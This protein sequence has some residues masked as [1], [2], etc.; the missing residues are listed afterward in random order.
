MSAANANDAESPALGSLKIRLRHDIHWIAYPNTNR[1]VA[2]DPIA[3]AFY[4]FSQLEYQAAL[5]LDGSRS[6]G[7]VLETVRNRTLNSSPT[8]AWIESFI[9]KLHRSELIESPTGFKT[10]QLQTPRN[11]N[12]FFNSLLANPLSIRIPLLRPSIEYAWAQWLAKLL[13]SP[14]AITA[15]LIGLLIVSYSVAS[16]LLSRPNEIL[17]DVSKIQGDRWLVL[18]ALL[19]AIKSLHE[20][21]HYLAC[22]HLKVR[23]AEIGALFLCFTPCLYCDTTESWKLPSRAHRAG[24]A[25]A[26][27]YLE[28]W[29]ALAGGLVFLNTQSGLAHVLGGGL[30]I[31]C[32]LGTLLLNAN[33]FFRYDG[34][35]ILSDLIGAP[36]LGAQGSQ[37]LW[38]SFIALLGGP[39]ANP[40]DFDLPIGWLSVFAILSIIYRWVVL[41]SIA[42]FLWHFL[43]P[44]GLG[45]YFL[46]IAGATC[47]GMVRVASSQT[48]GLVAQL[49]APE[50]ISRWRLAACLSLIPV[51]ILAI[52]WIPLPNRSVHRGYIELHD[53]VP[54]YAPEDCTLQSVSPLA[55]EPQMSIDRAG[56]VLVELDEPTLRFEQL[57]SMQDY[58]EILA[59]LE[60]Y[61]QAQGADET[62]A[63]EIPTLE[64]L[65]DQALNKVRWIEQ[66][67]EKLK[68]VSPSSGQF[69]SKSGWSISGY[70]QGES[71][72]HWQASL[73]EP[74][75][76]KRVQR[77]ELLGWF[78]SSNQK[79][80]VVLIPAETI[81]S[82][83]GNT[84]VLLVSDAN[85]GRSI[86][87]KI[88]YYSND[89]VPFFPSQLAGDATF[90]LERDERGLWQSETPLYRVRIELIDADPLVTRGGLCSARFDLP[91]LTVAQRIYRFFASQFRLANE[92]R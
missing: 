32:T 50:P 16:R 5:L 43:V 60:L 77:G 84:P 20:L 42:F 17:Y 76:G 44:S 22:V 62:L 72:R 8:S 63:A 12:S 3:N 74:D 73:S 59:R 45:L 9:H 39:R 1:W 29:I 26:G 40:Q 65:S 56:Q 79:E 36:N 86:Q 28:C 33:P 80:A 61:R 48:Y 11:Q 53:S 52:F 67:L 23:C 81:R 55:I 2:L 92:S 58:T 18:A 24:I 30:W 47:L 4:Y 91:R 19:V 6:V 49:A 34:Y 90:V 89:P 25:A 27:I 66:R 21:G 14:Y 69:L 7:Q 41:G 87:A 54:I 15:I 75:E 31:M 57:T 85:P 38:K 78:A 71:K 68:I 35:F 88:A 46:A 51:L 64:K 83:D 10:D 70:E 13:F 82:I 37:A